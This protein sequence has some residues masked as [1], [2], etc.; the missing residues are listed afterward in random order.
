MSVLAD[1]TAAARHPA[2]GVAPMTRREDL[3]TIALA[4]WLITGLFLDGWA[5][6][7]QPELESFFTPWHAVFYSGFTAMTA[8]IGWAAWSRR[9]PGGPIH[10][11][12]PRGYAPAAGGILLFSISG[13]GDLAWHETFG[14]EEGVSALLS[15]SH[16]GLFAGALLIV[17]APLRSL[18]SDPSL[19]RG[20][21]LARLL[22]AVLSLAIVG[23]LCAFM[24]MYLNVL[25]ES[26]FSVGWQ[27]QVMGNELE[28]DL[29]VTAGVASFIVTTVFL[30]CPL[31]FALARWD[32]PRGAILSVVGLQCTGMVA[33]S[34]FMDPGI[35][36]LGLI[37]GFGVEVL[38][39]VLRPSPARLWRVRAFCALAPAAF[40]SVYLGLAELADGAVGW[41][42]EVWGGAIVW[43]SLTLLAIS[44]LMYPPV[45][46]ASGQPE[47]GSAEPRSGRRARAH[48]ARSRARTAA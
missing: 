12:L 48:G 24:L 20:A 19:E 1:R 26:Y 22:P 31:L 36:A 16:L 7:A 41:P 30:F 32:L 3:V 9:A 29:N 10:R 40:W 18:W 34:G 15:P 45:L 25:H 13:L 42:P 4:A 17:T 33:L 28:S 8:W 2:I 23:A 37:A 35:I 47:P 44:F 39:H 46:P 21:S 5:H 38:A 11:S 27:H 43:S 14:I 6:G